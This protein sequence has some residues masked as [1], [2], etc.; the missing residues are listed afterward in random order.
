MSMQEKPTAALK[1]MIMKNSGASA[2][3]VRSAI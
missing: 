2:T 3:E 1:A